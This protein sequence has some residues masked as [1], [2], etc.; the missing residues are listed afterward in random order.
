MYKRILVPLDGSRLAEQALPYAE[1]LAKALSAQ[2]ELYEVIE[3]PP[4]QWVDS[5]HGIYPHRLSDSL[6]ST[7]QDYLERIANSLRANNL[8]VATKVEE[9]SPAH[10]IA[11]EA[12]AKPDTLIAMASHGRSGITRWVLGSVTDKVLQDT[13]CPLLI[14]RAD[15]NQ[16]APT[17]IALHHLIVPQ[18]GSPVGEQALPHAAALARAL[19]ANIRLVRANPSQ[20]EYHAYMGLYPMNSSSTVYTGMYEEFERAAD[21]QAMEQLLD[22][23]DKLRKLGVLS[24]DEDLTKGHAPELIVQ[25]AHDIPDSMVIMSSHGRAGVGRWIMGSVSDRVARHAGVPVLIVRA[26]EAE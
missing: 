24:V 23:K 3:P 15:E 13:P 1:I 21:A 26:K 17:S 2:L 14:I 9:G 5:A 25:L 6:R 11:V 7:R 12:E 16:S 20:G 4:D 10:C 18:D 8:S 19:K 22:A